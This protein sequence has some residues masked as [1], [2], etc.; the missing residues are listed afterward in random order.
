MAVPK[1]AKIVINVGYGK[2]RERQ[3]LIKKISQQL[4]KITGQ[5]PRTTVSK[6]AISGFKIRQA[7]PIGFQVTLRR[8]RARDFLTKLINV[9]IPRI[10]DFRG[11]ESRGFDQ[12]GNYNLGLREQ[13][14]FPE[15][16]PEESDSA[17]GMNVTLVTTAKTRQQAI[18]F[19]KTMGFP[20]KK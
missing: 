2:I 16:S 4:T 12:A 7:E 18:E 15:I 10:R 11:L 20:L 17:F 5:R 9:A 8:R 1:I 3:E 6:K 19:L 14:I 13:V